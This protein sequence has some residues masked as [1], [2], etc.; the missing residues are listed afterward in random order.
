MT[1][2]SPSPTMRFQS[3]GSLAKSRQASSQSSPKR[4]LFVDDEPMVLQGLQR[5]LRSL[6]T[7]WSMQFVGSGYEALQVFAVE[8]FDVV[9]TDMRMPGMNGAQLLDAVMKTAPGTVRLIL[10]GH[11]DHQLI[12]DSVRV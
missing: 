2:P 7:E 1:N 10:S 8:P 5:M 9:V 6:R 12:V 3:P 11:A 4:I